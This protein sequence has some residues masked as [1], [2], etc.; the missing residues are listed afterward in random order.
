MRHLIDAIAASAVEFT[1]GVLVSIGGIILAA[2]GQGWFSSAGGSALALLGGI[3]ASWGTTKTYVARDALDDANRH[4]ETLGRHLS[5]V[6]ARLQQATRD[7]G[8]G[9]VTADTCVELVRQAT[10]TSFTLVN[11]IEVM[12]G[13]PLNLPDVLQTARNVL[14]HSQRVAESLSQSGL[15]APGDAPANQAG[16]LLELESLKSQIAALARQAEPRAAASLVDVRVQ[17]PSCGAGGSARIGQEVGDSAITTCARCGERF[18][19]HRAKDLSLFC[20]PWGGTSWQEIDVQCPTCQRPIQVRFPP[21]QTGLVTRF[22]LWAPCRTD[23]ECTEMTVDPGARA[24]TTHRRV[25][26]LKGK[27]LHEAGFKTVALCPKCEST[28]TTFVARDGTGFGVCPTDQ[29]L[30]SVELRS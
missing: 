11:D 10:A 5:S 20:R 18:H 12:T 2:F 4:L 29:Q 24:V 6:C 27:Y 13:K 9:Q 3:L 22:C 16:Y 25:P 7:F 28:V 1:I 15:S 26:I 23:G 8:A 21:E 14:E 17:C 19:V 30:V